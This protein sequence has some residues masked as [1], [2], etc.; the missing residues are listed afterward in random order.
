MG[1][2][3]PTNSTLLQLCLQGN[4][5]GDGGAEALREVLR[6]NSTLQ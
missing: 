3:L 2:S 5:I 4:E 1:K 6:I